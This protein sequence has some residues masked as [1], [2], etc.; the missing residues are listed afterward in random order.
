MRKCV[1]CKTK[2]KPKFSS[3]QRTCDIPCAIVD[4]T[5]QNKRKIEKQRK[6]ERQETR[7]AKIALRTKSQW[8][9][10]TQPVFNKF[11]R[12]RDYDEPCI[13]CGRYD[14]EIEE[15]LTGGKW[16]CGHYKTIGAFGE[17][18]FEEKNAHKQCKSCNGGSGKYTRKNHTVGQD[19]TENLI[20]RIGQADVDWL[21][22]PHEPKKYTIEIIKQIRK[23][24][25]K[26]A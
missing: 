16:D 1:V 17:L 25:A 6:K 12:F 4:A 5:E 13:S 24:Y 7:Q 23:K 9:T 11:I 15:K 14:W 20:V 2:F 10:I 18:R 3:L 19:Y 22:G 26:M 21:N 8:I